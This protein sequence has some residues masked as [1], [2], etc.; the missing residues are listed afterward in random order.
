MPLV[1]TTLWWNVSRGHTEISKELLNNIWTSLD[2]SVDSSCDIY[3]KSKDCTDPLTYRSIALTWCLCKLLERMI[4]TC[5][6]W[7][8]EKSSILDTS[9]DP[10][11]IAAPWF[12]EVC[13]GFEKGIWDNL[14]I[15]YYPRPAQNWPQRQ[16]TCFRVEV[17]HRL[18]NLSQNSDYTL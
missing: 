18:S 7:C 9:V 12:R 17:P 10:G 16:T 2:I 14:V 11:S 15:W 6:I 5:F 3:R 4:H 1:L 8:L 13:T